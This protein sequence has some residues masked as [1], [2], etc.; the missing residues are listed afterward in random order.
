MLFQSDLDTLFIR[1]DDGEPF[2]D[3]LYAALSETGGSSGVFLSGIGMLR[4]FEIGWFN[5]ETK[6]YEK[7]FYTDPYELLS[8]SGNLSQKETALF[9]HFHVTLAGRAHRVIG[10]HLFGGTVCNTLEC[11]FRSYGHPLMRLPGATF[12]PLG[13]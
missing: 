13:F 10:G 2:F 1:L 9:A 11:F 7:K 8:L 4:S 3:T 5:M 12:S 6:A